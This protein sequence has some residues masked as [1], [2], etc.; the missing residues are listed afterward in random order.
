M[1][2]TALSEVT[3]KVAPQNQVKQL[4][5]SFKIE[6][7]EQKRKSFN[8]ELIIHESGMDVLNFIEEFLNPNS[9]KTLVVSTTT[10]FNIDI[11]PTGSFKAIINLQKTNNI[12]F[13]NKFFESI[14]SR[15]PD[16]GFF[17]GCVETFD[18]RQKKMFQSWPASLRHILFGLDFIYKRIMPK[19]WLTKRLYFC[20]THGRNRVLSLAECFGRLVSCGF[21]I[22]EFKEINGLTYFTVM[23]TKEPA[24]DMEPS[25]GFLFGMNKIGQNG[26]VIKL[27]K[28]RTMYPYS[29]YLQE[30]VYKMNCLKVGNNKNKDF[31]VTSWGRILR[32]IWIDELPQLL[33]FF[34]GEVK[35]FGVRALSKHIFSTYPK[36]LQELR[37]KFKPGLF[38]SLYFDLPKTWEETW[39]SERRYLLQ[40]MENPIS[41]DIK[42][43]A[44]ALYNVIVKKVRSC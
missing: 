5:N 12:R 17:I 27:Y 41:T 25:Y 20:L 33:N 9:K 18:Q 15:L 37:I 31:R 29:E 38:P 32:R 22:I 13:I 10:R 2:Q 14:N 44:R 35:L 26:N 39:E 3:K 30:Y 19:I 24:Y 6:L 1:E 43:L 21:D 7:L 16:A 36:D 11:Q 40:R 4:D 8:R 23:K 42:Y 34:R 28:I